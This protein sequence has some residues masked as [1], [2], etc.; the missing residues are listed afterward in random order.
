MLE[1]CDCVQ[2]GMG[3]CG[4]VKK[5]KCGLVK[6]KVW[7]GEEKS[8]LGEVGVLWNVYE[9]CLGIIKALEALTQLLL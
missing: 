8:V 5:K 7:L 1:R 4:L 6:K 9:T 2:N 3:Q